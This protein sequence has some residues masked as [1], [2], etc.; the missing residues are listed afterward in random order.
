MSPEQRKDLAVKLSC[1]NTAAP[2]LVFA[3]LNWQMHPETRRQAANSLPPIAR[4]LLEAETELAALRVVVARLIVANDRGDDRSL[5]DLRQAVKD[6]GIDL[7]SEYDA[8]NALACAQE[9]EAL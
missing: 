8:A 1:Y 5:G 6:A 2:E 4:N 3:A 7:T 9:S